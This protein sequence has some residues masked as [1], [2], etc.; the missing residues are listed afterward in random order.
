LNTN[1]IKAYEKTGFIKK[2]PVVQDIGLG[3][4]MDDFIMEKQLEPG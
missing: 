3:Y 2:G 4:V 1:A